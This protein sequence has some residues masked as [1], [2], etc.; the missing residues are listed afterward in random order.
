MLQGLSL[1]F[2]RAGANSAPTNAL[3]FLIKPDKTCYNP[4]TQCKATE[5][6]W[7]GEGCT[8]KV[9]TSCFAVT[10]CIIPYMWKSSFLLLGGHWGSL[11]TQ[12]VLWFYDTTLSS[13]S[14]PLGL[15]IAFYIALPCRLILSYPLFPSAL[16]LLNSWWGEASFVAFLLWNDRGLS[17]LL[18][19]AP[20]LSFLVDTRSHSSNC[21][22]FGFAD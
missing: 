4:V 19:W 9:Q 15:C 20:A 16:G 14:P 12:A 5:K 17:Q 7:A 8:A 2:P 6:N 10:D 21:H 1:Y 3:F 18:P 22:L 13:N 11:P